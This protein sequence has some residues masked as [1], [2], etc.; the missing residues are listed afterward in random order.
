MDEKTKKA[1][2]YV[3][4]DIVVDA[5]RAVVTRR[6]ERLTITAKVVD[7]LL[8]LL[9]RRGHIVEKA[10]LM[11]LLWPNS[12]VE[13][14]NLAQNVAVLRRALGDN[15]K[16]AKLIRTIPGRGYEFVGAVSVR[17]TEE[18]PVVAESNQ[19]D[20]RGRGI[21]YALAVGA[22]AA[23]LLAAGAYFFIR[24]N[25]EP[26]VDG[27]RRVAVLPLK[28]V[29]IEN[30][31]PIIEFAVAESLILKLSG[32][33]NLSVSA[34]STVRRYTDP[35]L[36]PV[37]VGR[38]LQADYVV[39]SNYQSVNGKIRVTAQL[40]DSKSGRS[41]ETF[42]SS[43]DVEDVFVMQDFV[44]NEIGNRLLSH[45][46]NATGQYWAKRGTVSEEAYRTY[47]QAQLLVERENAADIEHSIK[48]FDKALELDKNFAAAWAGKGRAHCA[49]SHWSGTSSPDTEYKIAGP[50]IERALEL[51]PELAEAYA[52]KGIIYTDYYWNYAEAEKS[53]RR[54]WELAPNVAS[55]RRWY[56]N[57]AILFGSPNDAME[58]IKKAIDLNPTYEFQFRVYAWV[59]YQSRKYD[60]AIQTLESFVET[61]SNSA[62]AYG[63]LWRVYSAKGDGEKAFAAFI[64]HREISKADPAVL[65]SFKTSYAQKGWPAVLLAFKEELKKDR[66]GEGYW[67]NYYA[68]AS[69]AAMTG[70]RE[71]AFESLEQAIK[72]KSAWI[73]SIKVEPALDPLR[74]DPRFADL[75]K[76]SGY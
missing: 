13:E 25:S 4:D 19:T 66:P 30:R 15:P 41:V 56:A 63:D 28:P 9:E 5:H 6:G 29:N 58:A 33:E 74:E 14:A 20:V 44:A 60:E 64:R 70:D 72:Y 65:D 48:L 76:R 31:D 43:T 69:V 27:V 55:Y 39:S 24:Q 26:Q 8:I 16:A 2:F 62:S 45:F 7:L 71:L 11:E 53:F 21:G 35:D 42:V 1:N 37:E 54:A 40:F 32:A 34:L 73:P 18:P 67:P 59:L 38:E 68:L 36:D 23:L 46:G 12:F 50:A 61:D 10:E 51:D 22:L 75:L 57:R 17:D 47:L 52:V 3:W 49:F